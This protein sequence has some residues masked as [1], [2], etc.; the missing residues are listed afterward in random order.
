MPVTA[1]GRRALVK[2][3]SRLQSFPSLAVMAARAALRQQLL[4]QKCRPCHPDQRAGA[5]HRSERLWQQRL[6]ADAV[7]GPPLLDHR[8]LRLEQ[9][10][11]PHQTFPSPL[12]PSLSSPF[13]RGPTIPETALA[14]TLIGTGEGGRE[15]M[16]LSVTRLSPSLATPC[17]GGAFLTA[18]STSRFTRST[19]R[20]TLPRGNAKTQAPSTFTVT[21]R[22]RTTGAT[23]TFR[24]R[25][26]GRGRSI[27]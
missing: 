5:G 26:Q 9:N 21:G 16:F 17:P 23:F 13:P 24:S 22:M 20:S 7:A 8:P 1:M 14:P 18:R 6:P 10:V 25:P 27:W 4:Q 12:L 11:S 15:T 2:P 19:W 3:T